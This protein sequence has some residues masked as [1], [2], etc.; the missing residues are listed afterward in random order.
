VRYGWPWAFG[1][2]G[3]LGLLCVVAWLVLYR[4]P[5]MHPGLAPSELAYIR[6]DPPDPTVHVPWAQLLHYRA[7]WAFIVGMAMSSPIWWFYLYWVPGFLFDRYGVDLMH[8]GPPLVVIYVISDFGSILGG[9]VS[10][11][12]I[13]RGWNVL[14]ARKVTLLACALCVVP[15]FFASRVSSVWPATLLIALAAAGHQGWAANLYTLVSDAMPRHTVSS[16]VG[17]GGFAGAVAG[18]FFAKFVGYVLQWTQ[19]Y[20][21]IFA[22]APAAYLVALSVMHVLLRRS[23]SLS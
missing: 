10:S 23:S 19:S 13:Q 20:V 3:S 17:I 11:R 5:E 9:W 18:M 21:L 7:T 4:R 15:V 12:L 2:T 16:V 14:T 8:M 1:V 6:S 22:L